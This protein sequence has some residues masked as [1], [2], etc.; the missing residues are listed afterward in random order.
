MK[1]PTDYTI[2]E[3]KKYTTKRP[4]K[5]LR[6]LDKF[7]R[8][9]IEMD[10]FTNTL[11]SWEAYIINLKNPYE[12][13]TRI[14]DYDS[15]KKKARLDDKSIDEVV[16]KSP[17]IGTESF[18]TSRGRKIAGIE[19]KDDQYICTLFQTDGKVIIMNPLEIEKLFKKYGKKAEN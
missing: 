16:I 8:A 3:S 6:S 5:I 9:W 13:K 15:S 17:E 10:G 2:K 14:Y 7:S 4:A 18:S 11:L 1:S 12:I 19:R